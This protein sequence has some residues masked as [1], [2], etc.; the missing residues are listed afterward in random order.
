MIVLNRDAGGLLLEE[1]TNDEID[2]FLASST[3][4]AQAA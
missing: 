2:N 4:K 3:D 1:M